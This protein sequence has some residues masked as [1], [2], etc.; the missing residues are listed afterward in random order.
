MPA[1]LDVLREVGFSSAHWREFSRRLEPDLDLNGIEA[2][3]PQNTKR[4]LEEVI[5]RWESDGDDPSWETL[6]DAV[7]KCKEGGGKNMA[8][9]IRKVGLGEAEILFCY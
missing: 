5:R 7:S 6:A 8:A 2:D 4:C 1:V 9:K 3:R